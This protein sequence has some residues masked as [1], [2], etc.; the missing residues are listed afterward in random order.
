MLGYELYESWRTLGALVLSTHEFKKS[1]LTYS[2]VL[3]PEKIP[4]AVRT[5]YAAKYFLEDISVLVAK[6]GFLATWHFDSA[7]NPGR[8]ALRALAGPDGSFM[9]ICHIYQGAQWHE[10]E[11]ADFF[12]V[13]FLGNDNPVP[14]L[15]PTDFNAPPPLLKGAESLCAL[16]DL[17]LFAKA[18]V[19]DEFWATIV[20]PQAKD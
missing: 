6:E 15:L 5:L 1:G 2:A 9:S 8:L 11:A 7:Q 10:R 4:A 17:K 14:L 12:G 18:L 19:F 20:D 16:A 13:S 3:P